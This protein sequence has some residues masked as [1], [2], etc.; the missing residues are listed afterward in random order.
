MTRTM[1]LVVACALL[2][3]LA[4][5][6]TATAN[7]DTHADRDYLEAG[8][9]DACATPLSERVGGWTCAEDGPVRDAAP[10]VRPAAA[11]DDENPGP[12]PA[13]RRDYLGEDQPDQCDV[14]VSERIGQWVCLD[15]AASQQASEARQA[16]RARTADAGEPVR[17]LRY[18]S[19][20]GCWARYN[21]ADSDF[22]GKGTFGYGTT[23][24]GSVTLYY[25]VKLNGGESRS[26][27]VNFTST[28]PT[29]SLHI[30]GDRL[31]YS[32]AYPGGNPVNDG[33]EFN[34]WHRGAFPAHQTVQWTPNGYKAYENTVQHT[35]VVHE[36][37][38]T[39]PSYRGAWY[40]YAKSIKAHRQSSGAYH[41]GGE[42]DLGRTPVGS[43]YHAQP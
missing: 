12:A 26:K 21:V 41:F 40:F 15:E 43:G 3:G 19:G 13:P 32:Q 7:A 23:P 42:T 1:K 16:E 36:W 35:S 25:E 4:T 28:A 2:M 6:G 8:Q 5:A 33:D 39:H 31:Y 30:E 29:K 17:P 24:I 9:A 38:W 11:A 37:V 18:C 27:P 34:S 10:A 14:P 20:K 22:S